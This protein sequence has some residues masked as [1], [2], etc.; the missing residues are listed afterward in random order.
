VGRLRQRAQ[1]RKHQRLQA[2]EHRQRA[3]IGPF[4]F[5]ARARE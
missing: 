1:A 2:R 5:A 4:R 3:R